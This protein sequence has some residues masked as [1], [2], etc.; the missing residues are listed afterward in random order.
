MCAYDDVFKNADLSYKKKK[1]A[2]IECITKRQKKHFFF[3]FQD[4]SED[5]GAEAGC[6]APCRI[7]HVSKRKK[8]KHTESQAPR[9]MNSNIIAD[10]NVQI[11]SFRD[12]EK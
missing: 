9:I 10:G 2:H 1:T 3:F 8:K 11:E 5:A 4:E 12:K 6:G 7:D